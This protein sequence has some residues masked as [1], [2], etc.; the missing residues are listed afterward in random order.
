[1][2]LQRH[3]F[4]DA[5]VALHA[6]PKRCQ[7]RLS[8]RLDRPRV[9]CHNGLLLMSREVDLATQAECLLSMPVC[10]HAD[11]CRSDAAEAP[12]YMLWAKRAPWATA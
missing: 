3:R 2:Q 11:A 5:A 4:L 6:L 8:S 10:S 9:V 7:L 1:M 12:G